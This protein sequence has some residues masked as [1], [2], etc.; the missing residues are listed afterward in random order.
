MQWHADLVRFERDKIARMADVRH[1]QVAT[2]RH[3]KALG[4]VVV[5]NLA[6]RPAGVAVSLWTFGPGSQVAR[7]E[8]EDA[9]TWHVI[10]GAGWIESREGDRQP[11]T[12]GSYVFVPK[13]DT[14]VLGSDEGMVLVDVFG[15]LM[16]PE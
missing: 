15:G 10:S 7:G 3:P 5:T 1:G 14:N 16:L 2:W 4:E 11:L 9:A 13:R 6:D 12:V 8:S